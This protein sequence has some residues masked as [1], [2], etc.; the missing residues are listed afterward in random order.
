MDPKDVTSIIVELDREGLENMMP[1]YH[2]DTLAE[3]ITRYCAVY[4]EQIRAQFP[5]AVITVD[6]RENRLH[7]NIEVNRYGFSVPVRED[8]VEEVDEELA[9]MADWVEHIGYTMLDLT[10]RWDTVA[11]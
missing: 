5:N 1:D 6:A 2:G 7:S 8:N 3:T 4:E 9:A 11:K 10:E